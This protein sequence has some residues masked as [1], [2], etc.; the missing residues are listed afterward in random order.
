MPPR[1]EEKQAQGRGYSLRLSRGRGRAAAHARPSGSPPVVR[2]SG[3]G[4]QG[5]GRALHRGEGGVLRGRWDGRRA[6]R[7]LGLDAGLCL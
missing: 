5:R 2:G 3:G 1:L 6:A 4:L 7:A